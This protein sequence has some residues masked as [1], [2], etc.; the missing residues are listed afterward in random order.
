M[1]Q[2]HGIKGLIY[3]S[4]MELS[5][6]NAW[7]I[8]YERELIDQTGGSDTWRT[9]L[10]GVK[11]W[12]GRIAS[13]GDTDDKVLFNAATATVSVALLIYPDRAD[14]STCWSGNAFFSGEEGADVGSAYTRA[15]Q[16]VGDST[17]SATGFS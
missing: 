8:A 11:D 17:L 9:R 13:W 1:A 10:V 12:R 16:F 7:S 2:K 5:A 4:G 6:A 14:Q 3:I 15:W